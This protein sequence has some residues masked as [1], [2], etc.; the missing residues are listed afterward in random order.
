M[1]TY[2]ALFLCLALAGHNISGNS[3]LS[4]NITSTCHVYIH[5]VLDIHTWGGIPGSGAGSVIERK[6]PQLTET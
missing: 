1:L 6:N 3:A 5:L 2:T 4:T